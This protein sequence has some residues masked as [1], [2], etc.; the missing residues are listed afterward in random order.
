MWRLVELRCQTMQALPCTRSW[1]SSESP[2]FIRSASNAVDGLTLRIG[3][4]CCECRQIAAVAGSHGDQRRPGLSRQLAR[5]LHFQ[6]SGNMESTAVVN[7][8]AALAHESRLTLFRL[9]V[10]RGPEGYTPG[11]IS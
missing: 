9:L 8:L 5:R 11:E 10:K 3:S 2:P 1:A 6:Y 7:A 4:L